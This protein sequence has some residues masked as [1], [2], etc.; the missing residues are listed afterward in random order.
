M[1]DAKDVPVWNMVSN[2]GEVRVVSHIPMVI[3]G[4]K[5]LQLSRRQSAAQSIPALLLTE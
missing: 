5:W 2:R 1:E 4:M 3:G